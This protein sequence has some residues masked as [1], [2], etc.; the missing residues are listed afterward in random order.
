MLWLGETC[1][2]RGLLQRQE[3]RR[4]IKQNTEGEPK[5]AAPPEVGI[6]HA[7]HFFF[8]FCNDQQRTLDPVNEKTH[9]EKD[10]G[11]RNYKIGAPEHEF[12]V[13]VRFWCYRRNQSN[14]L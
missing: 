3:L 9:R 2:K 6:K 4:R 14:R 1:M 13:S 11:F 12:E 5:P 7:I 8:G 10:D